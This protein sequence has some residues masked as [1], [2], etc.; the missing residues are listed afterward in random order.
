MS[1]QQVGEPRD[2]RPAN[3]RLETV[4]RAC[5]VLRVFEDEN[6]LLT[7]S[8]L[9]KRTGIEKTSA[10][11]IVHTLEHEGFLHKIDRRRYAR[12]LKI[13]CEKRFRV[14]YA[15]QTGFSPFS[16]AVSTSLQWSA[17]ENDIDLI[18]LDNQYSAKTAVRNAE[19]LIA[20]GVDLA[21][22]FQAYERVAPAVSALFQAAK[23]PLIAVEIPHPGA[24][25]FGI[26]N[27]RAGLAAG[28]ALAKAAKQMWHSQVEELLLLEMNIAGSVPQLRIVGMRAGLGQAIPPS[29][30]IHHLDTR[31]EFSH[32]FSAVRKHLQTRPQRRTLIAGINDSCVLGA[33]R[34][35]EEAGRSESALAVGM[36]AIPDA[37]QEL[38]RPGTR[39]ICSLAFFPEHYGERLI[40]LA[41]E[42]LH[43]REVPP[44]VYTRFQPI[45]PQNVDKFY[46]VD[47][48][49]QH[50][51]SS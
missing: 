47:L 15:A 35:F 42:M 32:A 1:E 25:Y 19:R 29:S 41:L 33:L 16:A 14:G 17:K 39:L 10:F 30:S 2:E 8:E 24:V 4:V 20:E 23:I 18:E 11:R 31:G 38:R 28:R 48:E 9:A 21:I 37:R 5:Q 6:E 27:Y 13:L 22:E 3:Q 26:D 34:A 7:L 50:R 44:S 51:T 49:S 36:G 40:H 45:T 43:N 12:R 46:P